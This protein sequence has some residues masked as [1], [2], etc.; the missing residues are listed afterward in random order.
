MAEI[1]RFRQSPFTSGPNHDPRHL[2]LDGAIVD[3]FGRQRVS[4]PF[5]DFGSK[6]LFDN[7]PLFW[8]DIEA[9]GT[10]TSSVHSADAA[11]SLLSVSATTAG[12]RTRQTWQDV[13]YQPGKGHLVAMSGVL[14]AGASGITQTIGYINDNNG[15]AFQDIDGVLGVT[16]RTHTSGS[17]VD[18]FV[19]QSAWNVDKLDGTGQSLVTLDLTKE[20]IFVIDFQWLSAGRVRFGFEIDGPIV[21]CHEVYTANVLALPYMSTPNLP[22][23]YVVG[24][25]GFFVAKLVGT[26]EWSQPAVAAWIEKLLREAP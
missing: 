20:N 23:T 1:G 19:A 25:D 3:A 5:T 18:T 9:S 13:N 8:E 6:Q 17:P 2:A 7:Q 14:G 21:Y 22:I 11:S 26:R 16:V 10:G 24:R 15:L 12:K 4:Q